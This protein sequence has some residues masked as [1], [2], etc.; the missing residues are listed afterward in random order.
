MHKQMITFE[1]NAWHKCIVRTILALGYWV[2]AIFASNG[3]Y[4]YWV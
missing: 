1:V 4:W 2:F 3:S